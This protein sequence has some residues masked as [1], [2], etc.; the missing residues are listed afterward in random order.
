[1]GNV[2]RREAEPSEE[3][4]PAEQHLDEAEEDDFDDLD[5]DD[6]RLSNFLTPHHFTDL[7][8]VMHHDRV[9]QLSAVCE[10]VAAGKP[11]RRNQGIMKGALSDALRRHGVEATMFDWDEE[12][13]TM[14]RFMC[15][16]TMVGG[17]CKGAAH[18][19]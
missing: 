7:N 17:V 16:D 5:L 12:E 14:Y 10:A 11:Y 19:D 8:D 4:K 3:L 18:S 13:H 9:G 2:F 6:A 1:M 15:G